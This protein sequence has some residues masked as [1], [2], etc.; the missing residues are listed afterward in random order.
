MGHATRRVVTANKLQRV[1]LYRGLPR[2][3]GPFNV[4]ILLNGLHGVVD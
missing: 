4:F 3:L 2:T 1:T